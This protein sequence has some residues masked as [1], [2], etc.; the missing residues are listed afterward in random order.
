MPSTSTAVSDRFGQFDGP[1]H[2]V[3]RAGLDLDSALFFAIWAVDPA[4]V[5]QGHFTCP[6]LLDG[7][8]EAFAELMSWQLDLIKVGN[9]VALL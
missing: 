6:F 7:P 9:L 5:F 4:Q 3:D 1:V 8:T 2:R